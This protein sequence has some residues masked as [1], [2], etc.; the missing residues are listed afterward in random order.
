M[1]S[2]SLPEIREFNRRKTAIEEQFDRSGTFELT[3]VE[4]ETYERYFYGTEHWNY[5]SNDEDLGPVVLSLKQEIINGR[6]QFRFGALP[7][8]HA[9][10]WLISFLKNLLEE[11]E[12]H[13]NPSILALKSEANLFS[14][15][16][17]KESEGISKSAA[18]FNWLQ[19][20]VQLQTR[21]FKRISERV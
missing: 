21:I 13:G 8:L 19:P 5:F 2:T 10:H 20:N 16:S 9:R 4:Q 14:K 12:I 18:D 17:H 11:T 1:S 7:F 3:S 15:N 6:D